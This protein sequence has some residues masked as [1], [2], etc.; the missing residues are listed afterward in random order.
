MCDIL[1]ILESNYVAILYCVR[2]SQIF[3]EN[4]QLLYSTC[5]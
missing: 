1:L 4:R 3:V 2:N 5:V